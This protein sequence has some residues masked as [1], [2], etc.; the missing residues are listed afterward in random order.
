MDDEAVGINNGGSV[1]R[2]VTCMMMICSH[3]PGCL[4]GY[5]SFF[6]K[7]QIFL[8]LLLNFCSLLN[9]Q[10]VRKLQSAAF[11]II[12]KISEAKKKKRKKKKKPILG[13][14]SVSVTIVTYI[15]NYLPLLKCI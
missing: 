4:G 10:K 8:R 11:F 9:G 12:T 6:A 1:I 5:Y 15:L 3:I 7:F 14:K 13:A 2:V